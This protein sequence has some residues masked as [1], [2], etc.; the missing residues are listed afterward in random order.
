[1]EPKWLNKSSNKSEVFLIDFGTIFGG[2]WEH[3]GGQ[4]TIK[5]RVGNLVFFWR[6]KHESA[7]RN[8]QGPRG[9]KKRGD[10]DHLGKNF[11]KKDLA[12]NQGLGKRARRPGWGGESL[13]AFRWAVVFGLFA[14]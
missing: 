10:K 13:R 1:M 6:A 3:F 4:N 5:N 12:K 14:W 2:F 8:A 11:R 9:E 7:R